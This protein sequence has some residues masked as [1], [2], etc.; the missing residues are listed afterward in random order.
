[1][2]PNV[3]VFELGGGESSED[4][5][6]PEDDA[7]ALFI[8]VKESQYKNAVSE[9]EIAKLKAKVCTYWVIICFA[10]TQSGTD[11]Q[12]DTPPGRAVAHNSI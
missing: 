9:A 8:K 12:S 2:P 1:M 3:E 10:S 11:G 7:Q 4:S 5:L 6:S